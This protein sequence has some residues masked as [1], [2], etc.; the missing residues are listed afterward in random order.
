M[1]RAL[2]LCL[3]YFVGAH[4]MTWF[5]LNGQFIWSWF[6]DH[7]LILCLF[8]V[9]V[10]YFYIVATKYSFEAFNGLLWPGR[11]VGFA[12]GMI[13]FTIFTAIFLGEGVNNK[14]VVSL[15]LASILVCIQVFW[16]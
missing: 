11:F 8:G 14:T 2:L 9:P 6:K 4:L 15:L 16:K 10:S 12:I 1:S 3:A 7:P 5:Q 13:A